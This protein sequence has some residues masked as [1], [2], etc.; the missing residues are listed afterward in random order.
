MLQLLCYY[1]LLLTS[2]LLLLLLFLFSLIYL[3]LFTLRTYR[4]AT[5]TVSDVAKLLGEVGISEDS[6][7]SGKDALMTRFGGLEEEEEGTYVLTCL[8]I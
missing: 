6:N 2:L 1:L 7:G 5:A 3:F 4:C 8:I